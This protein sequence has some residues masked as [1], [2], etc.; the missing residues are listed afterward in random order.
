VIP[1]EDEVARVVFPLAEDC[2][3][4]VRGREENEEWTDTWAPSENR[5]TVTEAATIR[6][7]MIF[8]KSEHIAK[9]NVEDGTA[10]QSLNGIPSH[11]DCRSTSVETSSRSVDSWCV[12]VL[13]L[14]PQICSPTPRA[15]PA[16]LC[17]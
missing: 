3:R 12:P 1:G 16:A 7:T 14:L 13:D 4:L 15:T 9:F 6:T 8:P 2:T 17:N 5:V 10:M 11:S